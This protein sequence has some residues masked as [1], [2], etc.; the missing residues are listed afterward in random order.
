M[1]ENNNEHCLPDEHTQLGYAKARVDELQAEVTALRGALAWYGDEKN[2]GLRDVVAG[3]WVCPIDD[4]KG[5]RARA[6]LEDK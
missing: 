4:D 1:T 6:A 5:D 2:Y 3:M